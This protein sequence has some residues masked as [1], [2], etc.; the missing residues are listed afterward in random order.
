MQRD[1][2]IGGAASIAAN[3]TGEMQRIEKCPADRRGTKGGV[4]ASTLTP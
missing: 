2:T 1:A 3:F 4:Q